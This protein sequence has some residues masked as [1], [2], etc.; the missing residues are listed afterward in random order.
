MPQLSEIR[1][2]RISR[3]M[4]KREGTTP[5]PFCDQSFAV[6]TSYRTCMYRIRSPVSRSSRWISTCQITIV[7]CWRPLQQ[8][9]IFSHCSSLLSLI[10]LAIWT[11]EGR[12]KNQ[13]CS[14]LRRKKTFSQSSSELLI[15]WS[16]VFE[17]I[18]WPNLIPIDCSYNLYLYTLLIVFF[19]QLTEY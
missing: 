18:V 6:D 15:R 16:T 3:Q 13:Q 17:T 5:G 9:Y 11:G 8:K 19:F 10:S 1:T 14:I 7:L 4:G 2:T 12:P